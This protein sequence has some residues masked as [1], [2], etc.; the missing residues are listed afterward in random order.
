MFD[1]PEDET[2]YARMDERRQSW[3][4]R[5]RHAQVGLIGAGLESLIAGLVLQ[6][7]DVSSVV[8]TENTYPG[9]RLLN[10]MGPV[11]IYPPAVERLEELG[12]P[13]EENPPLWLDRTELQNFLIH[14]Y[15]RKGGSCLRSVTLEQ[16]RVE[17]DEIELTLSVDDRRETFTFDDVVLS[18]DDFGIKT[19]DLDTSDPLEYE[20]LAT[21][22]RHDAAVQAGPTVLPAEL[23]SSA[24][25]LESAHVL[26]GRKAAEIVLNDRS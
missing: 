15:L 5:L 7:E 26:S 22:R 18:V 24:V 12:Y 2:L 10:G 14:S 9:H 19:H 6:D 13:V 8:L 20:V 25:P 4:R 16:S 3:F 11:P 21:G 23:S 1:R 17:S